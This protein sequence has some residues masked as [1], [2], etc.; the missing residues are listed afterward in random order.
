MQKLDKTGMQIVKL[1][2]QIDTASQFISDL[3]KGQ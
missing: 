2:D 3:C 1:E